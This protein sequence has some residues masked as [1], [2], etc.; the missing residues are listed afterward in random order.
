[1]CDQL[2]TIIKEHV[3]YI[4][5]SVFKIES[6]VHGRRDKHKRGKVYRGECCTYWDF[7]FV[8]PVLEVE[9]EI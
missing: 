6:T 4:L 8:E 5:W 7:G 9:R 2:S 1:M 3:T